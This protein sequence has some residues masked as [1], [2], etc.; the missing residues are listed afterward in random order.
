MARP[1][2][3]FVPRA[4]SPDRDRAIGATR[5]IL[6]G[7]VLNGLSPGNQP[8]GVEFLHVLVCAGVA[9]ALGWELYVSSA[10]T[11]GWRHEDLNSPSERAKTRR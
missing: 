3:M 8:D 9:V 4:S 2:A 5:I 11:H 6:V 10:A 7:A 1:L